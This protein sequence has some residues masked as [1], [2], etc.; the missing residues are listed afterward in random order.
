LFG[1]IIID[2]ATGLADGLG[3]VEAEGFADVEALEVEGLEEVDGRSGRG[4]VN[5][6]P[7][8]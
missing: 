6:C 8:G 3:R 5:L 7:M 4:S 2:G 1:Q